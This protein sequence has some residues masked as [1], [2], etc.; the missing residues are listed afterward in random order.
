MCTCCYG[1]FIWYCKKEVFVGWSSSRSS[2]WKVSFGD[3]STVN[4]V[5]YILC[6]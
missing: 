2:F 4:A 6:V 1:K 5:I 3:C